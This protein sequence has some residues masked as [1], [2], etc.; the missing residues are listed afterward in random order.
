MSESH[1]NWTGHDCPLNGCKGRIVDRAK[2][3]PEQD[4]LGEYWKG[5][6][7][8]C[9]TV[10]DLVREDPASIDIVRVSQVVK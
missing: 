1:Y 4:E 10:F 2:D 8:A 6:C 7:D 5:E 3:R 9:G